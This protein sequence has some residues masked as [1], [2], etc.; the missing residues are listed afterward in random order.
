[1]SNDQTIGWGIVGCGR[2]ADRRVAP[3]FSKLDGARLEAV[4]SR[5]MAKARTFAS[6]HGDPRAYGDLDS[7]LRDDRVQAVYVATPNAFH[8]E[9]AI[10]C[11]HAGRHVLVDKPMAINFDQANEM[12]EAARA[13][14]RLLAVL[15]QQR[16]HPAHQ[17]L[18]KLVREGK[19]GKIN[20]VRI[21]IGFWYPP[22][23]NWRLDPA[24]SGGGAAMDLA[25]HAFDLALCLAGPID[26]IA[27]RLFH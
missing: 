21:Q 18:L 23:G 2:V 12:V 25:P 7:L 5:D 19:L 13:S 3:V 22:N 10:R 27:A 20:I 26:S 15:H 16:F 1:M 6:R 14:D 24:L 11:L 9:Q 4:C 8:A 17:H